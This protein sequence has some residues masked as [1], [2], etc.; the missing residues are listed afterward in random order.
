M[1]AVLQDGTH[2]LITD[3]GRLWKPRLEE[4]LR[5]LKTISIALEVAKLDAVCPASSSKCELQVV[6]PECIVFDRNP[7]HFV[8]QCWL[9]EQI[10]CDAQPELEERR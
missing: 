9:P 7:D 10:L 5:A 1:L 2:H 8:K 4:L 3:L 6:T